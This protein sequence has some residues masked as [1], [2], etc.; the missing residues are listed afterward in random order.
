MGRLLPGALLC[1]ALVVAAG[2]AAAKDP[3]LSEQAL[4]AAAGVGCPAGIIEESRREGAFLVFDV[5]CGGEAP[6]VS[7]GAVFCRDGTCAFRV[8][9]PAPGTAFRDC[10]RCPEMA[11]L[12]PGSFVMGS[13]EREGGRGQDEGPA[14]KA[15]IVAPFAIARHETTRAEFAAFVRDTGH[16]SAGCGIWDHRA[17]KRTFADTADWFAPGFTQDDGHPVVCVS[18]EDA[19]A[20]ADWLSAK[21]GAAYRL[22]SE[23]EWEYAA[24]AGTVSARFWGEGHDRACAYANVHDLTGKQQNKLRWEPHFCD[25]GFGWTSPVGSFPPN[26]FGLYDMLGNVWE[27]TEDCWNDDYKG[28][29]ASGAARTDGNCAYRAIRGGSWMDPPRGARSAGRAAERAGARNDPVGF[30]V[31]RS[32]GAG[33]RAPE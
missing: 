5:R 17:R 8:A 28:A 6:T 11:T 29:P 18:W 10:P 9:E 24:R 2:L 19:R 1:A 16:E 7:A 26:S 21:T 15:R 27:W 33:L 22:P 4:Q 31:A 3:D 13:P 30:R 25:D 20:Y 14:H 23:A 12:P 32:L